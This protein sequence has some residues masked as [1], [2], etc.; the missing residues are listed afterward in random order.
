MQLKNV[1][2]KYFRLITILALMPISSIFAWNNIL[3]K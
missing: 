1:V 3:N 2:N